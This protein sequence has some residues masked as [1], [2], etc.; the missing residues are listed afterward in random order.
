LEQK[1]LVKQQEAKRKARA[2]WQ[3]LPTK[4]A[5]KQDE[6]NAVL[7]L[8]RDT[9]NRI[10]DL[11]AKSE[12]AALTAAAVTI[13]CA[14]A[15][16]RVRQC[17][18]NLIEAEIR[19]IEA[20]SELSSLKAENADILH[21]LETKKQAAKT[22]EAEKKSLTAQY[23]RIITKV[24]QDM[25]SYTEEE[26]EVIAEFSSLPTQDELNNEIET[27]TAK[28]GLMADGNP[29][30]V[31]AYENREREIQ[32]TEQRKE[33]IET[34]L[35]TTKNQITEIKEQWEPKVDELVEQI[36]DGFSRNFD[37]IGC[38][39]QVGVYKDEDFENWSIQI[40]VRFR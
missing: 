25:P 31:K 9:G 36:S 28:L 21:A 11:K 17:H 3:T 26:N 37:K 19:L 29:N 23:N 24:K 6:L 34:G 10:L 33:E 14:K 13:D 12:Q 15:F 22:L 5:Q 4:K 2:E 40:Q 18:E 16:S 38:A 32:R 20:D 1:E 27:V 8:M 30:A 39:G 35:Q 7:D